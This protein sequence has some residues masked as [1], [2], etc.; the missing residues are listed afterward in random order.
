[1]AIK[2]FLITLLIALIAALGH[3]SSSRS[4][5]ITPSD[6][7]KVTEEL[8]MALLDLRLLDLE[9]YESQAF[10]VALR[11]PRHVMQ[12]VRKCHMVI[13]KIMQQNG[14]SSSPL[15]ALHSLREI[16]PLDVKKGVEHLLNEVRMIGPVQQREIVKLK[17]KLPNDVYNNLKRM[18]RAL[19][20]EINS[21]DVYRTAKAIDE[22]IEKIALSRGYELTLDDEPSFNKSS[23]DVYQ[24]TLSFMD[25][26]RIL[27][28][29]PD[30]AIPGG[31]LIPDRLRTKEASSQDNLALM[32]DALAE[33]DA[34]K[35]V[36]GVREHAAQLSSHEE[37]SATDVFKVIRHAHN[38]VQ[39]IIE[40]EARAEF[41]G[42]VE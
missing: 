34:I 16:R 9:S 42:S 38:L 29:N 11:H 20:V 14:V 15:P 41:E 27:A 5:T 12:K 28:L 17:G 1:M 6:V 3:A 21:S 25:D 37:K 26:L 8:R 24:E 30:F 40:F 31:V 33:T 10:D 7:Y 13:S 22:N 32:N 39:K 19:N 23:H 2:H 36:L 4:E 35:Y 18:C